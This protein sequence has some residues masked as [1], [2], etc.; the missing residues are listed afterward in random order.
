MALSIQDIRLM[1]KNAVR[2]PSCSKL[3]LPTQRGDW[4][5]ICLNSRLVPANL[6][7]NPL[8]QKVA[9]LAAGEVSPSEFGATEQH[10]AYIASLPTVEA[11]RDGLYVEGQRVT[12][13]R[14]WTKKEKIAAN[15]VV[16]I[17]SSGVQTCDVYQICG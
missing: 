17:S 10:C 4:A 5:C 13:R 16:A 12:K 15:E 2:C 9:L 14:K 11:R 8:G 7:L 3:L 1:P 6:M